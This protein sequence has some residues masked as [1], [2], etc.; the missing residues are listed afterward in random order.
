[1]KVSLRRSD[2]R[3]WG[4]C[5]SVHKTFK[6]SSI[7]HRQFK[8]Q[9]TNLKPKVPQPQWDHGPHTVQLGVA[10]ILALMR[11][12]TPI[13]QPM[14]WHI[15]FCIHTM[16]VGHFYRTK[17]LKEPSNCRESTFAS[18]TVEGGGDAFLSDE[19]S[20]KTLVPNLQT[21]KRHTP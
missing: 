1:M 10:M 19:P 9:H 21:R 7:P 14:L 18:Q 17:N 13:S 16:K 11:S 6:K 20:S 5:S 12:V 15:I 3:R 8:E 4:W 2:G